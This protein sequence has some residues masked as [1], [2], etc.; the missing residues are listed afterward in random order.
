MKC[1]TCGKENLYNHCMECNLNNMKETYSV[2]SFKIDFDVEPNFK[3]L[4]Y[5]LPRN[6]RKRGQKVYLLEVYPNHELKFYEMV[7]SCA[8]K[9]LKLKSSEQRQNHH[10]TLTRIF[11]KRDMPGVV[12]LYTRLVTE[13]MGE[14]SGKQKTE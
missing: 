3:P 13:Y 1:G 5:T 6:T 11:I 2:P 12:N 9:I 10:T 4:P 14:I 8:E 7:M